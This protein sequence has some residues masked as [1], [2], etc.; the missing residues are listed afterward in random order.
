M[1]Q[2]VCETRSIHAILLENIP[3]AISVEKACE[4]DDRKGTDY[5]VRHKRME[6]LSIDVKVRGTD[7]AA[8]PPPYNADDLALETWSV[9]ERQVPGW[10]RDDRKQTDYI[11]WFWSDTGRWCIVPFTL[12]CGAFSAEWESWR[13]RYKTRQ[14]YTPE[15]GYHSEC[16]FVPRR[17]VW[18]SIYRIYG[19]DKNF[20]PE[21]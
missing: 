15:R 3:G 7:W 5:W 19:G 20:C 9:V 17:E 4:D 11:M 10:T 13:E 14:Q 8:K 18:A 2:G 16:V 6:P 21:G 12:L 1:S